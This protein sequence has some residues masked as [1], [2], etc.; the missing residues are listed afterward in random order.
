MTGIGE[1][2]IKRLGW[3][4]T[5]V[6]YGLNGFTLEAPDDEAYDLVISV[7]TGAVDHHESADALARWV[8]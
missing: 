6:F 3:L 5:F 7:A 1:A 4:S 2:E 8:H